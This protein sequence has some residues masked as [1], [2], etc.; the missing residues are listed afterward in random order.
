MMRRPAFMLA[1]AMLLAAGIALARP[2]AQRR[3]PALATTPTPGCPIALPTEDYAGRFILTPRLAT[4][5]TL[6]LLTDSGG[7]LLILA[8]SA[9]RFGL[10]L[11]DRDPGPGVYNTTTLPAFMPG[12]AI[13]APL[14][15]DGRLGV[16]A[17]EGEL[18]G[19][20]M[21][22]ID[23]LLG[24]AYFAGR[25]WTFDYLRR[26]ILWRAPGD[27]PRVAA[28]HRV[29][30]AF[31]TDPATGDRETNFARITVQ[32]AGK[33]YPM[34]LDTGA[35]NVLSPA[36]LAQIGDG[37]PANRATSFIGD[38]IYT[39]WRRD[40][41]DWRALDPIESLAGTAM[42]EVPRVTIAG[43]TVGPVWF[44][45]EPSRAFRVRMAALMDR[46]IEGSAGGTILRFFRVSVDYP[47]AVAVFERAG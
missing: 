13:P 37:G 18:G 42:I 21:R 27:L 39:E 28:A 11:E 26:R 47:G 4:G 3:C 2:A 24:E 31:K 17:R 12:H 23:G 46:P 8:D 14:L 29:A 32:I 33:D 43:Y 6:R 25:T 36:A 16:F 30:L 19:D 9:A 7:G 20:L 15:R 34:L 35:S 41:P 1:S 22:G 10:P 45:V 5:E 44:S 40:H 38:A